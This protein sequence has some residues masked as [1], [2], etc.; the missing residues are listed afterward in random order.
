[1]DPDLDRAQT[2]VESGMK[3]FPEGNPN[4]V[5]S[6][7][8]RGLKQVMPYMWNAFGGGDDPFDPEENVQIG[9]AI[10]ADELKRFGDEKLA[11][12]AYNAGSPA[13]NRAIQ[14]AGSR[15]FDD[16][17]QFLPAETQDYVDKIYTLAGSFKKQRIE[18][19]VEQHSEDGLKDAPWGT[20][21][22][23]AAMAED[24]MTRPGF[25]ELDPRAKI[26][27][28]DRLYSSQNWNPDTDKV[29]KD[30]T[31]PIWEA[32]P[33]A[34]KPNWG[35]MIGVPL[36]AKDEKGLKNQSTEMRRTFKRQLYE[37]GVNPAIFGDEIDN[38]FKQITLSEQERLERKNAGVLDTVGRGAQEIAKGAVRNISSP[39]A[40]IAANLDDDKT[41]ESIRG[42]GTDWFGSHD[43]FNYETREDG[44]FVIGDDGK[45]VTKY[46]GMI[47]NGIG[48]IGGLLMGGAGFKAAGYG[49]GAV[50]AILGG[51]NTLMSMDD[52][53]AES[54]A[55]GASPED[56]MTGAFASAP[57]AAVGGFIDAAILAT[58]AYWVKG[59]TGVNRFRAAAQFAIQGAAVGAVGNAVSE[60]GI[61]RGVET[62]TGQEVE[63][64][65]TRMQI[66]GG[67][68]AVAGGFFGGLEGRGYRP[69]PAPPT[70]TPDATQP[71][72][73]TPGPEAAFDGSFSAVDLPNAQRRLPAPPIKKIAG[74]LPAPSTP[75]L[76]EY[77]PSVSAEA[78]RDI[79]RRFEALQVSME[80]N[81]IVPYPADQIPEGALN[82]FQYDAQ[83]QT[84][85]T[86]L[87]TKRQR[88]VPADPK[89]IEEVQTRIDGLQET[90]ET[91]PSLKSEEALYAEFNTLQQQR[92]E[93]DERVRTFPESEEADALNQ[94]LT[95]LREKIVRDRK[96]AD[97]T[98]DP[99]LKEVARE[100][101]SISQA[102]INTI[103]NIIDAPRARLT[104]IDERLTQLSKNLASL[105]DPQYRNARGAVN[106]ELQSQLK[107]R[108]ELIEKGQSLT[109][110]FVS[111]EPAFNQAI[112]V[113][114]PMG[115]RFI[116]ESGGLWYGVDEGGRIVT[117]GQSDYADAMARATSERIVPRELL[118]PLPFKIERGR[119]IQLKKEAGI[120]L[121]PERAATAKA[122]DEARTG[123]REL[124][125]DARPKPEEPKK[126]KGKAKEKKGK[127]K[128]KEP[129]TPTLDDE[130]TALHEAPTLDEF[131]GTTARDESIQTEPIDDINDL[132]DIAEGKRPAGQQSQTRLGF[133][134][135][136]PRAFYAKEFTDAPI[137]PESFDIAK[138]GGATTQKIK[139]LGQ[140][141]LT[142]LTPE[143]DISLTEGGAMESG[144]LGY[145]QL[146]Q[147]FIKIG[148]VDDI[149][150]MIHEIAHAI[151]DFTISEG[152]LARGRGYEKLPPDVA[153]ALRKTALTFYP[154]E[155]ILVSSNRLQIAEGFT[156]FLQ[157]YMTN[158]QVHPTVLKWFNNDFA[159]QYPKH[160]DAIE[161]L[162]H[163]SQA[164]FAQNPEAIIR[165]GRSANTEK[166][167]LLRRLVGHLN[168]ENFRT[169]TDD[170]GY[171]LNI[172][173]EVKR[174]RD[175]T[176]TTAGEKA[177]FMINNFLIDIWGRKVGDGLTNFREIFAEVEREGLMDNTIDYMV[178]VSAIENYHK[179][180]L[181]PGVWANRED[182][183]AVR[184]GYEGGN[185]YTDATGKNIDQVAK[186]KIVQT[187]QNYWKAW[188]TLTYSWQQSSRA[189]ANFYGPVRAENLKVTGAAHGYYLPF[190]RAGKNRRSFTAARTG[191]NRRIENPLGVIGAQ[192]RGTIDALQKQAMI[193]HFLVASASTKDPRYAGL[194]R[195]ITGDVRGRRALDAEMK[196]G[197]Q[198]F[199]KI[200]GIDPTEAKGTDAEDL[201]RYGLGIFN[202]PNGVKAPDG[203]SIAAMPESVS[204]DPSR[205]PSYRY[206][207]VNQKLI[208]A[209]SDRVAAFGNNVFTN[210][211]V[212]PVKN[213]SQE[214][215]TTLRLPFQALN[216]ARDF[217][218]Y[219]RRSDERLVMAISDYV[220]AWLQVGADRA[221]LK[222][223]ANF[224]QAAEQ[225]GVLRSSRK[226]SEV[227]NL[228]TPGGSGNKIL[229]ATGATW[230]KFNDIMNAGEDVPRIAAMMGEFRR[231]SGKNGRTL[232]PDTEL[233][234]MEMVN[235]ALA[236]RNITTNRT[237]SGDWGRVAN[238]YSL[239]FNAR[240]QE[241]AQTIKDFKRRPTRTALAITGNIAMGY[242]LQKT[243]QGETW[244][245]NQSPEEKLK[246]VHI[247][248]EVDGDERLLR[249][250]LGTMDAL[251]VAIGMVMGANETEQTTPTSRAEMVGAF[252][253][254]QLP[255]APSDWTLRGLAEMSF[256]LGGPL[257]NELAQQVSGRDFFRRRP[258]VPKSLQ[259]DPE[260][261][262]YMPYTLEAAKVLG[263]QVGM[264]PIRVE[265]V[266]N[267][268]MPA[269]VDMMRLADQEL[270]KEETRDPSRSGGVTGAVLNSFLHYRLSNDIHGRFEEEFYKARDEAKSNKDAETPEEEK[271]R[272]KLE[273][274]GKDLGFVSTILRDGKGLSQ[275]ERDKLFEKKEELLRAG[276][277]MSR[278]EKA[279]AVSGP[280]A[281]A[282][283]VK[284]EVTKERTE[285]ARARRAERESEEE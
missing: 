69:P 170:S 110:E 241:T 86:T 281:Q 254:G 116:L 81:T 84:D 158:Q 153:S 96:T 13:V 92:L 65:W 184:Q 233:T 222:Q 29:I 228:G 272:K 270:F 143:G 175:A 23:F 162:R 114:S 258:I 24:M 59:L 140:R 186:A 260:A 251:G 230:R 132:G 66:A 43:E 151:D 54:R 93:A 44:S 235:L 276:I 18:Q 211:L 73:V 172:N 145:Y 262:Q 261:E 154:S 68:G 134:K 2:I 15:E 45:P 274:V 239:F 105:N 71:P 263:E 250:G 200:A 41:A 144:T 61:M 236:Y 111:P 70:P 60:E 224:V 127:K 55:R 249:I 238:R 204:T 208:D 25:Q 20:A 214:M 189:A 78:A 165:Q 164:F 50:T 67:V 130:R 87:V 19:G 280:K 176:R 107:L 136:N 48:Q 173:P 52:T 80:E 4:A 273:K 36:V 90:L 112:E 217:T 167:S 259:D 174:L 91:N 226:H 135:R 63:D 72:P 57:E 237:V 21:S 194:V 117:D 267:S 168:W 221:G 101:A 242:M 177:K 160:Y 247:P 34:A 53:Y 253:K 102:R 99:I 128:E 108:R 3:G 51:Q 146:A 232:T 16:I 5:S 193:E 38:Y 17:A 207:E 133:A 284:K 49:V 195:E 285:A 188:D 182:A 252:A 161:S 129:R 79:S 227:A 56:A 27:A 268:I 225:L 220:R 256:G 33:E 264:S 100:Q 26:Q 11:F 137:A 279:K 47:L 198:D 152:D 94:E 240:V 139:D 218:T 213:F 104:E 125:R 163:M 215:M 121:E 75:T 131:M 266:L 88:W 62:A 64:Y 202:A 269:A 149:P 191:S 74:Y 283:R 159:Q 58:G 12:A 183:I 192:L 210:T 157:N 89:T 190:V 122:M 126:A 223:Y 106:A 46:Q 40:F 209:F 120:Y 28:I 201:L 7:G 10:Y 142:A 245:E 9:K 141:I 278:G 179:R 243:F 231:T 205:G 255:I 39:L 185:A 14:K 37:G 115:R 234:P 246:A 1:M 6:A 180:G 150:T 30:I 124:E 277:A 196:K 197:A 248:I 147:K 148:S 155:K 32:T 113:D 199:E 109:E 31:R 119:L 181:D 77:T 219:L 282:E 8:A 166:P 76:I 83:P 42:W 203:W 216:I 212:V 265:H 85:G 97:R 103:D 178:S 271:T 229:D 123:Q 138:T 118:E 156:M 169:K 95:A 171:V 257:I 35:D 275:D 244:F 187:A 82:F 206:F 22:E 98:K